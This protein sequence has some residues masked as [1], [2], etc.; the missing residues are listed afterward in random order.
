MGV[1]DSPVFLTEETGVNHFFNRLAQRTAT[2]MGSHWTFIAA[3]AACLVWAVTGPLFAYSDTWQL[4]INTATTVLTFLAVFLIQ[5]TQN[6]NGLALQIKLDELIRSIDTARTSLVGL[7]DA[8]DEEVETLRREFEI[9]HERE[10]ALLASS[11]SYENDFGWNDFG[12][13]G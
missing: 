9:L 4:V 12:R 3:T 8:T 5:N 1:A 10:R 7:E 2:L 11:I 13:T 6:R